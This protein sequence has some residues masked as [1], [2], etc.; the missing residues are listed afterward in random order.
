[1]HICFWIDKC[2]WCTNCVSLSRLWKDHFLFYDI[3]CYGGGG[4]ISPLF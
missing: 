4:H 1:M 2:V 3:V